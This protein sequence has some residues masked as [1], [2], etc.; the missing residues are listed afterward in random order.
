MR[1]IID[2]NTDLSLYAVAHIVE[3]IIETDEPSFIRFHGRDYRFQ[4][5][6][7][8]VIQV[9]AYETKTGWSVRINDTKRET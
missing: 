7:G 8:S 3:D 5:Y 4:G 6:N 1:I 2:N 9:F